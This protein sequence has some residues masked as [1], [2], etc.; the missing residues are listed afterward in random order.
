MILFRAGSDA[1][2]LRPRPNFPEAAKTGELRNRTAQTSDSICTAVA[3]V[4]AEENC[5]AYKLQS[6]CHY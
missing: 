5:R 6:A 3:R 4:T 1:A 2:V